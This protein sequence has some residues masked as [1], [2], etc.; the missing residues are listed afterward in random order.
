MYNV[1]ELLILIFCTFQRY[2]GL[3]FWSLV[4]SST[5]II[6]YCIAF[7]CKFFN[8]IDGDARWISVVLLTI[9]WVSE[10]L[11]YP[12]LNSSTRLSVLCIIGYSSTD[13]CL[14]MVS[15]REAPWFCGRGFI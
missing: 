4:I 12:L 2:S 5:A 3:Y 8:L 1:L 10:S 9:G 11:S 6:P 14:S 15:L 7:I 13:L